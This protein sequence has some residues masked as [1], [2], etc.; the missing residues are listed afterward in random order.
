MIG[1][2][3]IRIPIKAETSAIEV[4]TRIIRLRWRHAVFEDALTGDD[5]DHYAQ[6]PFVA[7]EELFVYRNSAAAQLWDDEGAVLEACNSMI[8]V[9]ADSEILTVVIDDLDKEMGTIIDAIRSAFDDEIHFLP[10]L[11]EAA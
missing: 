10:A 6:I 1:G 5:Y 11:R 3:D 9:I 7:I 8:H 4:A 2:I